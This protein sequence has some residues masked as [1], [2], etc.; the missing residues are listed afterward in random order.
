[1]KL[2]TIFYFFVFL[3]I[4][5]KTPKMVNSVN[6]WERTFIDQQVLKKK[7]STFLFFG[8]SSF[9]ADVDFRAEAI[10]TSINLKRSETEL[11]LIFFPGPNFA[12]KKPERYGFE[13]GREI[14]VSGVRNK[15]ASFSVQ[16]VSVETSELSSRQ[17]FFIIFFH[18][19]WKIRNLDSGKK[20]FATNRKQVTWS[21]SKTYYIIIK[22]LI[23]KIIHF[24]LG[25]YVGLE[26]SHWL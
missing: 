11:A 26:L 21:F 17:K 1:M 14:K 10:T 7:L 5:R 6:I 25:H 2:E 22:D 12:P 18:R 16:L 13:I 19:L 24:N 20:S 9:F 8:V 23:D 15:K 3:R 4:H